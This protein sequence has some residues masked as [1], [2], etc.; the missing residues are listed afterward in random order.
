MAIHNKVNARL[1][2]ILGLIVCFTL[3][4]ACDALAES[5]DFQN[6]FTHSRFLL[7]KPDI[8]PVDEVF[9][10]TAARSNGV[11]TLYW[12]ILPG[13]YLYRHRLKATSDTGLGEMTMADGEPKLDEY[14]GQVEVYYD[15]LEVQILETAGNGKPLSLTVEYQGCADAGICYPPQKKHLSP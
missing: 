10:L 9:R 14:F 8:L 7:E 5:T 1:D 12:Q 3:F 2:K 15:E 4:A 11:V 13:Y 6:T